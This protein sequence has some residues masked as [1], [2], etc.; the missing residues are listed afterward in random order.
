MEKQTKL[1]WNLPAQ[2][3]QWSTRNRHKIRSKLTV[4]TLE[5]HSWS[6][7]GVLLTHFGHN[8]HPTPGLPP[9][10][11]NHQLPCKERIYLY[12][13]LFTFMMILN[14]REN[15]RNDKELEKIFV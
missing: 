15:H 11:L 8:P 9:L 2:S 7:S 3:Q 12:Y 13:I 10:N 6:Y 4:K 5:R 14:K 1:K